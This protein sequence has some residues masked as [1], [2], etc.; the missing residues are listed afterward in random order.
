M[1]VVLQW[2]IKIGWEV[3]GLVHL[4]KERDNSGTMFC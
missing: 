1:G 3:A 4:A 2:I